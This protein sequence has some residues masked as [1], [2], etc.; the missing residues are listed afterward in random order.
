[1]KE[2]VQ[3]FYTVVVVV[4]QCTIHRSPG[5]LKLFSTARFIL[6][7]N[8][9]KTPASLWNLSNHNLTLAW[10]VAGDEVARVPDRRASVRGVT[11][12]M[13]KQL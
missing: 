1:M 11:D 2:L 4:Y 6:C 5:E 7:S 9:R 10:I 8:V 3:V 13:L 12:Y